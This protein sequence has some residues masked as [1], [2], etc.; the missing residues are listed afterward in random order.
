[1][2]V[3]VRTSPAASARIRPTAIASTPRAISAPAAVATV[4]IVAS[5]SWVFLD[6]MVRPDLAAVSRAA[7]ICAGDT[8]RADWIIQPDWIWIQCSRRRPFGV[9]REVGAEV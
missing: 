9:I 8:G 1:M 3:S 4:L 2:A 7:A 6:S 5:D